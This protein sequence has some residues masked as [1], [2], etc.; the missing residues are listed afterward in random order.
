MLLTQGESL[1]NDKNELRKEMSNILVL[2]S[3]RMMNI[4]NLMLHGDSSRYREARQ[5]IA[6]RSWI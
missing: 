3:D 6:A 1:A 4:Q 5:G 2:G